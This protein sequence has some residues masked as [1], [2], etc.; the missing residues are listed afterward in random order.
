V[1]F[2]RPRRHRL[3]TVDTVRGETE[4]TSTALDG[5]RAYYLAEGAVQRATLQLLWTRHQSQRT[6]HP[7]RLTTV[8]YVFPS[9]NVRVEIIPEASK[10][11]VNSAPVQDLYRLIASLGIEPE[12]AQQIAAGIA[13]WRS[14]PPDGGLFDGYYSRSRL[15]FGRRTRLSKRSRKCFW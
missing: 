14:R 1:A 15:R 7:P 11:D 9:G 5:L 10:L 12:R 2:R 6:P 4:R 13:D 3:F 8:D